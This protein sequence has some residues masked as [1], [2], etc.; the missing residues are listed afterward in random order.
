MRVLTL[1]QP[2]AGLVISGIKR[3]E[4]RPR[5]VIRNAD[6]VAGPIRIAIHAGIKIDESAYG[7]LDSSMLMEPNQLWYRLS[8]ITGAIIGMV[9]VYG[10]RYIG[11][12]SREFIEKSCETMGIPDQARWMFGPTCY[13][14]RDA[15]A[16]E[17]PIK[18]RGRQGLRTVDPDIAQSITQQEESR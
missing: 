16:L 10:A 7:K 15:F 4:N 3:V 13:L 18:C 6:L 1:T 17:E 14:L 8:R 2:W 11:G 9:T 12:C 5:P